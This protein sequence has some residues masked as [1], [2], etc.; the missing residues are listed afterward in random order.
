MTQETMLRILAD[1]KQHIA[2]RDCAA[3]IRMQVRG[4][5]APLEPT[6]HRRKAYDLLEQLADVLLL[7]WSRP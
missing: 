1:L 7:D 4:R 6:K 5:A 3:R 2:F